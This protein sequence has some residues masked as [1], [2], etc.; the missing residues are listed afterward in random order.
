MDTSAG[1]A[2]SY[3]NPYTGAVSNAGQTVN[4]N[5]NPSQSPDARSINVSNLVDPAQLRNFK[6]GQHYIGPYTPPTPPKL[7]GDP[8]CLGAPDAVSE[9]HNLQRGNA[10]NSPQAST[11]GQFGASIW[12]NTT[13]GNRPF[14]NAGADAGF[15]A[16][17]M[18]LD[19]SVAVAN[20]LQGH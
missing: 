17:F 15:A 18:G 12:Q 3:L 4:V 14:G 13:K 6:P 19:Y 20:C 2:A 8:A 1:P 10:Q 16:G 9:I 5:A 11:D 7:T